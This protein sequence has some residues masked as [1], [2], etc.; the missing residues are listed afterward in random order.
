MKRTV[1]GFILGVLLTLSI[2]VYA[3]P[4]ILSARFTEDKFLYNGQEYPM[5]IAAIKAADEQ[6]AS[7][8]IKVA[9]MARA[10][11]GK[12][13]STG[14]HIVIE[15]GPE[16]VARNCKDSCVMIYAYKGDTINQGSG[17]VYNGYVITA[18]HV[19][20][21]ADRIEVFPDDSIYGGYATV[22]YTDSEQDVAVLKLDRDLGLPS[23]TL[24]DSDKLVEGQKLVAIAS[25]AGVQNTIDECMYSGFAYVDTG[26]YLTLSETDMVGGSSGGAIFNLNGELAAMNIRGNDGGSFAIPINQIKPILEKLK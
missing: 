15:S 20:E 17:W 21:G 4:E 7:T 8:Y 26:T 22:E 10:L 25:P 13:Y 11:G 2:G 14:T 5:R 9:D 19:V 6:W 3:V 12:A 23:V 24:G 18:K 1:I 16:Y